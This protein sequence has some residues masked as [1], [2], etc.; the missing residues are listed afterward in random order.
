MSSLFRQAWRFTFKNP[1]H[2]VYRRELAGWSYLRFWR[3][4]RKG[5]LPLMLLVLAGSVCCCSTFTLLSMAGEPVEL[6]LLAFGLL[7][8]VWFGGELIQGL[9]GLTATVLTATTISAEVQADTFALLRVTPIPAQEIV[10]AKFGAVI[11]QLRWPVLVVMLTRG[12]F[13]L[14]V[15]A[16]IG[17]AALPSNAYSP[18]AA[19]PNPLTSMRLLSAYEPVAA[20]TDLLGGASVL[21]VAV[22]WIIFF[23]GRSL[24]DVLLFSA[25]GL[26]A[27]SLARTRATGLV[28]AVGIRIFLGGASYFAANFFS[29]GFSMLSLLIYA[30]PPWLN[31]LM[32]AYPGLTVFAV[33]TFAALVLF[34]LALGEILLTLLFLKIAARRT[35]N[36]PYNR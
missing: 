33:A 18:S 8:G 3:G 16:V 22:L 20:L 11:R 34:G 25:I 9:T 6:A 12:L 13:V 26:F 15:I 2:P 19:T 7:A 5:C 30:L 35:Q 29:F 36:L 28:V 21:I 24:L 27:S 23:L 1:K 14:G 4:L 32:E 31:S 10:L 17:L